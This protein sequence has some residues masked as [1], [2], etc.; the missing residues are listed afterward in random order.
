MAP[1]EAAIRALV[2]GP[3]QVES[4]LGI[5]SSIPPG[6]SVTDLVMSD[7]SVTVDMSS[8]VLNGLGEATLALIFDQFRSTLGDFPSIGSIKLTCGGKLLA[9]YLPARGPSPSIAPMQQ[10]GLATSGVGLAGKKICIGPSHGRFWSNGGWYWQ[11]TLTCGWGEDILEDTNSIR[12]VQFLK[13][14]LTQDG[15]TF[16]TPR[17]LDETDGNDP[18][19]GMPWWKMCAES[20]LHHTG[21]PSSVWASS[22]G[23]T[24]ADNAADRNGDDIRAR[25]LYADWQGSDIYIACHTN[26]GGG[27]LAT[28]T[29]TYY[30]SQMEHPSWITASTSLATNVENSVLSAIQTTY[31]STWISHGQAVKDS[32]GAF[33]EIRIPNRPACLIELAFHDDCARDASYL[34]DDFFR[35]VAE[36]GLYAGVC[37]YF[38]NTPTWDKYSC[39]YISDTIPTTMTPGQSYP[40]SV[41]FRNRGVSWFTTRGFRLGAIGD[42]NSF[43][44]YTRVDIS[45]QVKPGDTYTFNF[46]LTAPASG[47]TYTAGWRMVRDGYAWFGPS[48]SK[49]VDCGPNLDHNAPSA[50]T[51]V[52]STGS[53]PNSISFAWNAA[54]DDYGV[55]GYRVYRNNA[56]IGTTN[57]TTFTDTGLNYST[58]YNY[59]VDAY[60]VVPNYSAK[61]TSAALSTGAP[62]F[63]TW[64]RTTSNSDCYLRSGAADTA[65]NGSGLAAGW[66]STAS[67]AIRRSLVQWDMTGAPAQSTIVNAASSVRVKL[68]CYTRSVNTA[69]NI[70]L[71]KVTADWTEA[72]ATWNNMSANYSGVYATASVGAVGDYTW[73]WNGN[74]VGIPVQNRGVMIIH[75]QETVNSAAKVFTDKELTGGTNPKPRLEI[76]YYDVA[77]PTGCSININAGASDTASPVVT[78][79]LAASDSPSGMGPGAQ[80][81][82]SDDGLNYSTPEAYA[83]TKSYTLPAGDGIKSVFVKFKD[84]AGNWSSPVSDTINLDTTPPT[85]SVLI[86][87]GDTYATSAAVTLAPSSA[88]ADQMRFNNENGTWSAWEAYDTSKSWTLSDGDGVK[89]VYVQFK[90]AVGNISTDSI[91]DTI[92][93]DATV[94]TSSAT[95]AGGVYNA[96]QNVTLSAS[97]AA[98]I[99]Y[100]TD[101]TDPTTSSST[102]SDPIPVSTDITLRFFA[103]DSAGNTESP[104]KQEDYT[105]LTDNG[106][107]SAAKK[108]D[109]GAS[110]KLGDKV[111]YFKSDGFGYVEDS[112]RLSGIR[113]EGAIQGEEGQLVCFTGTKSQTLDG[114]P[115]ITVTKMTPNGPG[116]AAPWATGI[117]AFQHNLLDGLCV[118]TYGKVKTGSVTANSYVLSMGTPDTEITVMTKSTPTVSEGDYVIVT[119]ALGFGTGRVLY[120]K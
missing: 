92:T 95:P 89:T 66:S 32:A 60:D 114:E 87:D 34:I 67:I 69:Y 97:E 83:A 25:P 36:W 101:G 118:K 24:G 112:G 80:M 58:T 35:S 94:P 3:T 120:Q 54:T 78:L 113:V 29:E 51:N 68:Y 37:A 26:A 16:T 73:S 38:G 64:S 15:A 4:G 72:T 85:G 21:A 108:A 31:D 96:T 61:S 98:T 44:A 47:G 6:T 88:N 33:G 11:R 49:T 74:T 65:G 79:A 23:N 116:S 41:T 63:Y 46:T 57:G 105:I 50:P 20:W 1:A 90:D 117:Q 10:G 62:A 14:Y 7:T 75:Q 52:H 27:G 106:S 39:E 48:I 22:S 110:V 13:Q 53:T 86:N 12:L 119:G 30:D 82:F 93:V 99:Y 102:Y 76:D 109:L 91:S 103:A 8:E 70:D 59:Q 84:V 42:T 45:G 104:I 2:A 111:L 115:V 43:G 17:Q 55:V 9:S 28:G 100:T 71:G 5:T 18:D 40:V 77:A 81:Q 56:Q 107:V 19:T